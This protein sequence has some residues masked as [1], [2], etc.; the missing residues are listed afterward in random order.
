MQA[1]LAPL[2]I[3][4][5]VTYLICA[6]PFGMIF[7]KYFGKHKNLQS[8]G[9]GNIGFTNAARVN[10]AKVGILTLLF[11]VLKAFISVKFSWFLLASMSSTEYMALRSPALIWM[12]A[13]VYV[14][15]V[16]G[17][18]FSVY[19]KFHGGKGIAV[20][21]G[22]SLAFIPLTG[23]SILAVFIIV[24][25]ISKYVSLGSISAALGLVPFGLIYAHEPRYL[26]LLALISLTVVW[27]HRT[28]IKKLLAGN[29]SRIHLEKK[30]E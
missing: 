19:L 25:L 11:D 21:L 8:V 22:G 27:A 10:G 7:S 12:L 18:V 2:L 4:C 29:E 15:A 24:V 16:F 6:I 17:H 26:L 9:S 20:G 28:N 5:L 13:L 1:Y 3:S 23:L 14:C 30:K